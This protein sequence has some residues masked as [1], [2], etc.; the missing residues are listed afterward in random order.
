MPE[1]PEVE[2]TVRD[3]K[4]IIGLSIINIKLHRNNIRYPIPKK[5]VFL[6]KNSKIQSIIRIA[7]YIVVKLS[8]SYSIIIHLGMSGRLKIHNRKRYLKREVHDHIEIYLS[9]DSKLIFNDPRR[10]GIFDVLKTSQI[11]NCKYFSKLGKDPFDKKFEKI[12]LFNKIKKSNSSI[13]SLLLNQK[14]VSGIGNIYACEI[15]FDSKI[16]PLLKGK[17]ITIKKTKVLVK[18][19]KKILKIAIN[20]RGT[21]LKNYFLING[22]L[23]SYQNKFKVYNKEGKYIEIGGKKRK[24]IKI[25]QSGRST[26]LCPYVQKINKYNINIY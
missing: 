4:F 23:G 18:S 9:N 22:T 2:T 16:S 17:N 24:I 14:I 10:F 26:F 15:L 12:Y 1:L 11:Y 20:Y 21:S 8:S 3:L 5:K 6:T 19:I 7:K 25:I 13:K